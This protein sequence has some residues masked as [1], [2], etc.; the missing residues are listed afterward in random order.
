MV[1]KRIYLDH[2]ATT[3]IREEVAVVLERG[4]REVFGNPSST[5]FEGLRARDALENARAQIAEALRVPGAQV[6]F[7]SGGTESDHLG[8]RGSLEAMEGREDF[9]GGRVLTSQIEHPAVY[10]AIDKL[11]PTKWQSHQLAVDSTGR[12][13]LDGLEAHLE[14]ASTSSIPVALAS[15][16]GCNNEVGAAQPLKEIASLLHAENAWLHVDGVQQL[17]KYPLDMKQL[18]IDLLTITGHKIYGPKG[19]GALVVNEETLT[20]SIEPLLLGG[21]QEGGLRAGTPW[22]VGAMAFSEAVRL[23]VEEQGRESS[24]LNRLRRLFR[25]GLEANLKGLEFNSSIEGCACHLVHV[26]FE[27]IRGNALQEH[28]DQLGISV[29]TGSACH[30]EGGKLSQVLEAM[31]R[32]ADS[33]RASVRFS[34][35]KSNTEEQIPILVETIVKGVLYLRN[36]AGYGESN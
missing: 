10:G 4:H 7:T 20:D 36:L 1:E 5:H 14:E 29:S 19:I 25:E 28:L 26:A 23:A 13:L 33:I 27:G 24:R 22:V 8:I 9:K 30:S 12:V 34:F 2:A 16:I 18:G 21:G 3:P 31:G 35:G 17:G 32:S 6:I 11:D 15:I